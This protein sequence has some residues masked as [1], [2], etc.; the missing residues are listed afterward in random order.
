MNE[1]FFNCATAGVKQLNYVFPVWE[2]NPAW[3][4]F[5]SPALRD[6]FAVNAV[7]QALP[8]Q[9][10]LLHSFAT[11]AQEGFTSYAYIELHR[12]LDLIAWSET[13]M[14][15][16][17][18]TEPLAIDGTVNFTGKQLLIDNDSRLMTPAAVQSLVRFV[19]T[20]GDLVIQRTSGQFEP[21][22]EIPTWHL[23]RALD[24][25]DTPGLAEGGQVLRESRDGLVGG[26][27]AIAEPLR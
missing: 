13:M 19:E 22:S 12:W 25:A 14:T 7:S 8:S 20:G 15:P 18:W 24:Y 3:E 10:G 26:Q 9:V 2:E 16:G 5:A 1:F 11:G 27:R 23:L 17:L 4:M 21:D 6:A